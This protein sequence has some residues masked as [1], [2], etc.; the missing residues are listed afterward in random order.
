M[1]ARSVGGVL[2]AVGALVVAWCPGAA[3]GRDGSKFARL[4]ITAK[5]T[6]SNGLLAPRAHGLPAAVAIWGGQSSPSPGPAQVHGRT[7]SGC[8]AG[9]VALPARGEGFVRR[10]P[11]RRTG[12]GHPDLVDYVARL[13]V[14]AQGA[15]VGLLQIG[16][17]SLP[18][19]GAFLQGHWSHQSGLDVDIAYEALSEH[20]EGVSAEAATRPLAPGDPSG[21]AARRLETLL[22]LAAADE[23]VDR[24]FVS[25]GIKQRLCEAAADDRRFLDVLRPWVGHQQHFHVRLKCPFDSPDCRPNQ[26]VATIP[27]DCESLSRWWKSGA[28]PAAFAD[29]R[30]LERDRYTRELPDACRVLPAPIRRVAA[31]PAALDGPSAPSAI[32]HHRSDEQA[33]P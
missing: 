20:R 30:A 25:A 10:R 11:G 29:W 24:I 7:T 16:D 4:A 2:T 17:L 26:P 6:E 19:G 14:A 5:P 8:L 28:V 9:A 32:A 18:R 1:L 15:G 22:R 3:E 33:W 12:F 27:D 31:M 13:G 21:R 23:R